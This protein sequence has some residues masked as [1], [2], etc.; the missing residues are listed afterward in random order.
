MAICKTLTKKN[1]NPIFFKRQHAFPNTSNF[2]SD[3]DEWFKGSH[4]I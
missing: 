2:G 4:F 3:Y 1:L